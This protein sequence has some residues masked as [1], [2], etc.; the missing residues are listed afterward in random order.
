[1][2]SRYC[3][4]IPFLIPLF[5][6]S[7]SKPRLLLF[8]NRLAVGGPAINTLSAAAA[9]SR[10]F[11]I[12]LVAGEPMRDEQSADFLLEQYK[13]FRVERIQSLRRS[14]LPVQDIR[15]YCS[16]KKLIREF[17]PD[18][19]HTHGAKPGVVGRLAGWRL[20]VPVIIHTF[21]GH[22]FHSYFS[23]FV[24]GRI[25]WIEQMLAKISTA[26]I[27]INQTLNKELAGEYKIAAAE[28]VK[29]IRLGVETEKFKDADGTKRKTFRQE[30]SLDENE[31]AVGIIGRLVPVKQHTLFIEIAEQLLQTVKKKLRFFIV[32]NGP[33]KNN[34]EQL[35][36]QKKIS[37]T[38]TGVS[39]NE[40]AQFVFTS[41][42]HDM[43]TVYAGL[44]IVMLT[45]LNEGTPVSIME[46]M[47]AAKPVVS[48]NAGGVAELIETGRTGFVGSD[49]E[50]LTEQVLKLIEDP[51]GR[52]EI[53]LNAVQFAD[54]HL[55]KAFEVAQLKELYIQ[56]LNSNG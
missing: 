32:G 13:G 53:A 6:F 30:F 33:E 37:Y 44:D 14:V 51:A 48:T 20:K 3:K 41:W 35:L 21:H 29:L 24:S 55:S 18:I 11:D 47:S 28:K 4:P 26:V 31:I 56:L 34:L 12:L 1:M 23:P 46:A 38:H 15:S 8:L 36:L 16:I 22:V 10:D 49:K 52:R 45:S 2:Y 43:D 7:L 42:R 27:A 5:S 54:M 17:K 50:Q 25:V 39:F 9:L 19:I 40:A